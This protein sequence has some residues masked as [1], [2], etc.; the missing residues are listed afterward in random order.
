MKQ[1]AIVPAEMPTPTGPYSPVIVW[2]N[3]VFLSGQEPRYL[4]N[5]Q[6]VEGDFTAQAKLTLENIEILLK[7]ANSS[8]E[9]VLKVHIF[10]ADA[11]NYQALNAV[12]KEFFEG[13]VF[14]ARR[15]T[16]SNLLGGVSLEI[17]V[18]AYR[19]GI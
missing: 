7:A 15:T 11:N 10:L 18:I 1:E 12:Y 3:L 16:I 17:D 8:R 5:G 19:D 4:Q 6:L 9:Q 14:P 2:Q 13:C